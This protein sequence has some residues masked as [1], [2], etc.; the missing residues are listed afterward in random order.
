MIIGTAAMIWVGGSILIHGLH[1][2]GM[3]HPYKEI[4]AAAAGAAGLFTDA[5]GF[6]KWVVTA[7]LDG[8]FGL[9]VGLLTIPVVT[10]VLAPLVAKITGKKPAH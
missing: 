7:A 1:E 8:V 6:V 3:H 5:Q 9:I 4:K 2:L 10:K